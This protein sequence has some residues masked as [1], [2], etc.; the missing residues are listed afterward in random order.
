MSSFLPASNMLTSVCS[1]QQVLQGGRSVP[2]P[3]TTY[4]CPVGYLGT[5]STCWA[6]ISN[7]VKNDQ[8]PS[9]ITAQPWTNLLPLVARLEVWCGGSNC[10]DV[11]ASQAS[12]Q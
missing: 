5:W 11:E 7:L 10:G 6:R 12:T 3:S 2:C 1:E 9:R 4:L 8:L